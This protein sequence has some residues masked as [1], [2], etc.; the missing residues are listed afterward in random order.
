M[1]IPPSSPLER[2]RRGYAFHSSFRTQPRGPPP[3]PSGSGGSCRLPAKGLRCA[4]DPP[5]QRPPARRKEE[6]AGP[7]H[8]QGSGAALP[9][10]PAGPFPRPPGPRAGPSPFWQRGAPLAGA[11]ASRELPGPPGGNAAAAVGCGGSPV[12]ADMASRSACSLR[13]AAASS[14]PSSSSFSSAAPIHSRAPSERAR[15]PPPTAPPSGSSAVRP[16][17]AR[18]G[19]A[20]EAEPGRQNR[21]GVASRRGFA[22]SCRERRGEA[23]RPA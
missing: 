10:D 13:P 18:H 4:P 11:A 16:R 17:P 20:A 19:P 9:G 3:S 5:G 22:W 1:R 7:W 15:A 21:P 8:P 23:A 12:G 2:S 14:S 6:Q